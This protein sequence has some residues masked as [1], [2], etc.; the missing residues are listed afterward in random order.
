MEFLGHGRP[1]TDSSRTRL[2][3]TYPRLRARHRTLALLLPEHRTEIAAR[4]LRNSSL[5]WRGSIREARTTFSFRT[6]LVGFFARHDARHET[7]SLTRNSFPAIDTRCCVGHASAFSGFATATARRIHSFG[8][9]RAP[10]A[11]SGAMTKHGLLAQIRTVPY[12][13]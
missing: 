3:L 10:R 2:T 7:Y 12:T 9:A 11:A 6:A 5:V 1:G 4:S 13:P 8:D